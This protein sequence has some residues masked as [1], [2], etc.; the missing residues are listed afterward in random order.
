MWPMSQK[1]PRLLMFTVDSEFHNDIALK[2]DDR[3]G[4]TCVLALSAQFFVP[5]THNQAVD[6][7]EHPLI[8]SPSLRISSGVTS[9]T[10]N[11]KQYNRSLQHIITEK[12]S[13]QQRL[14]QANG[15]PSSSCSHLIY[16]EPTCPSLELRNATKASPKNR[17]APAPINTAGS[18]GREPSTKQMHTLMISKASTTAPVRSAWR[19]PC[20]HASAEE[21][22]DNSA[23]ADDGDSAGGEASGCGDAEAYQRRPPRAKSREPASRYIN[24]LDAV[25]GKRQRRA[26]V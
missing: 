17:E 26:V 16:E 3:A 22:E 21:E 24:V 18:K 15:V 12:P 20:L 14:C 4:G 2:K 9:A 7:I 13:P 10:R 11:S 1:I 6:T 23:G 25:V 8:F 5:R 19:K